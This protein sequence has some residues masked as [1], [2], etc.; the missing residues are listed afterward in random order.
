MEHNHGL[1]P[2]DPRDRSGNGLGTRHER[3]RV[4]V[5][6]HRRQPGVND[7]VHRPAEG[8]RRGRDAG[9]T[10]KPE[11]PQR[12]LEGCGA[13]GN[14][15]RVVGADEGGEFAL[16]GGDLR[17]GGYPARRK[18]S[19]NRRLGLGRDQRSCEWDVRAG[20]LRRDGSHH[21]TG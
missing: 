6:K 11:R 4:D 15:D 8:H 13:G 2:I 18:H 5:D 14:R 16:E 3:P 20:L 9:P 17:A 1:D 19:G 7:G 10:G 21:I 12:E